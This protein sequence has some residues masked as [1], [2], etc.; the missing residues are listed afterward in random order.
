MSL[1][2]S[3]CAISHDY[4][5]QCLLVQKG[6]FSIKIIQ[7]ILLVMFQKTKWNPVLCMSEILPFIHLSSFHGSILLCF[8]C[9]MHTCIVQ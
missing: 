9:V 4:C 3:I 1:K 6:H 5:G 2:D 8:N 7:L